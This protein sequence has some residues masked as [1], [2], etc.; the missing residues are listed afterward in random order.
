MHFGVRAKLISAFL[1]IVS[2][3]LVSAGVSFYSIRAL[4]SALEEVVSERV[5]LMSDAVSLKTAVDGALSALSQVIQNKDGD[6]E[7][8]WEIVAS[9]LKAAEL[10]LRS[11]KTKDIDQ[12]TTAALEAQL[13]NMTNQIEQIKSL[14]LDYSILHSDVVALL[15]E[16]ASQ[17]DQIRSDVSTDID[18]ERQFS[19][20]IVEEVSA[21][22]VV[23]SAKLTEL[24][25]NSDKLFALSSVRSSSEASYSALETIISLTDETQIKSKAFEATSAL[26]KSSQGLSLFPEGVAQYYKKQLDIFIDF[27]DGEKGLINLRFR[28][29]DNE[30]KID[31]LTQ[32]NHT[33]STQLSQIVSDLTISS[34]QEVS[35]SAGQAT[36][37]GEAM[38][39]VIWVVVI[40]SLVISFAL[41]FFFVIRH[42]NRRLRILSQGMDELSQ[43]NL[44]IEIDDPSTDAIGR[45]AQSLEFFRQN[46]LQVEALKQEKEE[47]DRRAEEEKKA[48]LIKMSNDF[49]EQVVHILDDVM[50]AGKGVSFDANAL[51]QLSDVAKAQANN[52]ASASEQ[53]KTDVQTVASA[54]EE[55][56]ASIRSIEENMDLSHETFECAL[57]ASE[58]STKRINSLEEVG[59]QVASVIGVI[60]DIAE[61]TNLLAL[62]ATIEAQRAGEQGKG[63]GVVASE[64][65]KLAEQTSQATDKISQQISQM[66]EA[67]SQ[68]V[69]AIGESTKLIAE[70]NQINENTVHAIR[71]QSSATNEIASC[72]LSASKGTEKV[73]EHIVDVLTAAKDTNQSAVRVGETSQN[74]VN[75]SG[76]LQNAVRG[77]LENIRG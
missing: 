67:T 45:M 57:K 43:G 9:N 55:L 35:K 68:A 17:L 59:N 34:R 60:S 36:K 26:E 64:V 29:L 65:K 37:I 20:Q 77:F 72:V 38:T 52:V 40:A 19:D 56:S 46:A 75:Q 62:N 69:Q 12:S 11:L 58:T 21:E 50:K 15:H 42:L 16:A 4:N 1:V 28:A 74:V 48:S 22:D 13:L 27:F 10:A 66:K 44:E 51:I 25:Q 73:N 6:L 30:Q 41:I 14:I 8:E 2:L 47:S 70:I 49:E 39:K 33:L 18:V 32:Q 23:E 54:S 24:I 61:Q 53:A 7:N 3:T 76:I 71:E 63:F 5:P 31:Q